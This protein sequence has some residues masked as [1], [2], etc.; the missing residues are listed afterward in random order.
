MRHLPASVPALLA[1][2]L[3][4]ACSKTEKSPDTTAAA[5]PPPATVTPAPPAPVSLASL[6]GKWTVVA[7]PTDGK[8][9]SPTTTT[10]TATAD[11]TGW[12][13]ATANHPPVPIHVRADGDSIITHSGPYDS[14]R[15]K[16]VKVT[17][18]GVWHLRDGKLV[19]T[20]V[21][22]YSVKTAD[23]VLHLRTE[24]TKQP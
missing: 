20:T 22:R 8:D 14:F 19:G 17:T 2:A 5:A 9:T 7:T 1:V 21:A 10:L 16:G 15:R 12:S 6:A 24:G 4:A 18:D 11:T 3:L 13:Q 23:S